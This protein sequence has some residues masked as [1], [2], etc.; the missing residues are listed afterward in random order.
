MTER[1]K[2]LAVMPGGLQGI[3]ETGVIGEV[4]Q[5][6]GGILHWV[7]RL[8]GD[9][10]PEAS[11]DFDGLIVFGGEIGAHEAQ[12][13]GYFE[14]LYRLIRSFHGEE[15]PV[16]GSCLGA[17][18]IAC[19]FGGDAMPQGFLEFGFAELRVEPDA[20]ADPLLSHVAET[21]ALFE[22]HNDTFT[23]PREA[24]PLLRGDRVASQVYR[25]GGSTYGFQCHFEATSDIALLWT[26]RELATDPRYSAAQMPEIRAWLEQQFERFGANQRTFGLTV[27]N[28]WMDLLR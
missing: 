5:R 12:H 10:L 27:M 24:V 22:M 21:I 11:Q 14:E 19:A 4:V 28:R 1:A 6:R 17:Q 23:L 9:A 8:K 26:G 2:I 18:S 25:I 7:Y 3:E 13:S 16:F 15:K 20:H